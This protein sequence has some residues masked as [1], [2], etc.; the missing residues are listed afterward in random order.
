MRRELSAQ[1]S[2][3]RSTTDRR[4]TVLLALLLGL[5]GGAVAGEPQPPF[6]VFPEAEPP[7][8]RVR[9]AAGATGPLDLPV[10]YTV[11]IP[12][13]IETLRGVVIHQHG[14]GPGSCSSGLTGA[15]DLHWQ[16]LA[17]KHGC[18]LL[19]P[20]YE[21]QKD[22]NCLRWCDPRNGSLGALDTAL[23]D[24]AK[25]S[26]H[27]EL[28]DVPWALW[29]HSG[30]GY[31]AGIATLERPD[32]I[33]AAWLRS[34]TPLV[35]PREDRPSAKVV[36]VPEQPLGVPMM[37]NLGTEEGVTKTDT[38]FAG[39]WPRAVEF[40]TAT[41]GRGNLVG[42]AIDP[43]TGHQCGNQRY[44]AIPW[45]DACL[46][47]RLPT[48]PG[49]PLRPMPTDEAWLADLREPIAKPEI[50]F[51]GDPLDAGWLP[52]AEVAA[53]WQQYVT[54]ADVPDTTP[55]PSPTDVRVID[56]EIAW[57]ADADLQSG[58]RQ[59]VI[60]KDNERIGLV[61]EKPR[62]RFGRPLFQDL[63]YSDTPAQPLAEMTFA[64]P[65]IK[66]DEASRYTVR[67]IN[68][69]GLKSPLRP[70]ASK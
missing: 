27:D 31:W 64:D 67:A 7:Y 26:G 59:F 22:E 16:A 48:E 18:A 3:F 6:D 47:A 63:L 69:V 65:R 2:A 14:C 60:L 10:K 70:A 40:F 5:A 53:A 46:A 23:A 33:A 45:F 41:R 44:L 42:V 52:N 25:A 19:S 36:T 50:E 28:D 58:V 62:N 1:P 38:K 13:G 24:L 34:G 8:Y 66:A 39:V 35:T 15:Y 4:L 9:Y 56:G 43:L 68:T 11:W 49:Q 17:K 61:P 54:D 32:R 51:E 20:S 57:T 30:G 55:P 29:G 12:P 37:L 21:Q